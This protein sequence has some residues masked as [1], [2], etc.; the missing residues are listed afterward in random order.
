M[1]FNTWLGHACGE[2]SIHLPRV[3]EQAGIIKCRNAK[4]GKNNDEG[5]PNLYLIRG[6]RGQVVYARLSTFKGGGQERIYRPHYQHARKRPEKP[7]PQRRKR[8][9]FLPLVPL[10][11]D[12]TPL[13]KWRDLKESGTDYESAYESARAYIDKIFPDDIFGWGVIPA[14]IQMCVWDIDTNDSGGIDFGEHHPA[15]A[16]MLGDQIGGGYLVRTPGGGYH[17]WCNAPIETPDRIDVKLSAICGIPELKYKD[18]VPLA[19]TKR[20]MTS[21][22]QLSGYERLPLEEQQEAHIEFLRK[23]NEERPSPATCLLFIKFANAIKPRQ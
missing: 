12:R 16:D 7:L 15:L 4:N 21:S 1:D 20:T 23:A 10:S 5:S 14:N 17:L 18:V 8:R 11:S 3:E 6:D 9:A 22:Y 13:I 19:G 2:L